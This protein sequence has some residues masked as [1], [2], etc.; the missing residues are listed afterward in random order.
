MKICP[1]SSSSPLFFTRGLLFFCVRDVSPAGS[2]KHF[3]RL[4]FIFLPSVWL[5]TVAAVFCSLFSSIVPQCARCAPLYEAPLTSPH[6]RYTEFLPPRSACERIWHATQTL[7]L[8]RGNAGGF[9]PRVPFLCP[10]SYK[11]KFCV[12]A[13]EQV[14]MCPPG[15]RQLLETYR[16]GFFFQF[17]FFFMLANQPALACRRPCTGSRV[18]VLGSV[19]CVRL[20]EQTGPPWGELG[21]DLLWWL[22]VR[23]ESTASETT[24]K[25]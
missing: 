19:L 3:S 16:G 2:V 12:W 21:K 9:V 20:K 17:V 13:L 4:D 5:Y 8:R 15:L 22:S 24:W 7:T 18:V 6:R 1:V 25:V 11:C 23:P 10:F 14:C